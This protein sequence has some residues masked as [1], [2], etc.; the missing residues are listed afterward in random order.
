[1]PRTLRTRAPSGGTRVNSLSR[2]NTRWWIRSAGKRNSTLLISG[3][4]VLLGRTPGGAGQLV[5]VVR[6]G[7]N[8][9]RP[10]PSPE[11]TTTAPESVTA[12]ASGCRTVATSARDSP[13][14]SPRS[15]ARTVLVPVE[16][17]HTRPL[18]GSSATAHGAEGT[19]NIW[20]RRTGEVEYTSSVSPTVSLATTDPLENV[21]SMPAPFPARRSGPACSSSRSMLASTVSGL[22]RAVTDPSRATAIRSIDS[23]PESRFSSAPSASLTTTSPSAVPVRIRPSGVIAAVV[24]GPSPVRSRSGPDGG[25]TTTPSECGT[26]TV[27]S[28]ATDASPAAAGSSTVRSEDHRVPST[29][30]ISRRDGS[31]TWAVTCSPEASSVRTVAGVSTVAPSAGPA[32]CGD[33]A[34]RAWPCS[35]AASWSGW[36]AVWE[37]PLSPN[38]SASSAAGTTERRRARSGTVFLSTDRHCPPRASSAA[39]QVRTTTLC[40]GAATPSGAPDALTRES[41]A[42][43]PDGPRRPGHRRH[44]LDPGHRAVRAPGVDRVPPG[45]VLGAPA[46]LLHVVVRRGRRCLVHRRRPARDGGGRPGV[47]LQG[48]RPHHPRLVP[49]PGG[50]RAS[51]RPGLPARLV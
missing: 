32:A 10:A 21:L 46:D 39:A 27:P 36:S 49:R 7:S 25:T 5:G 18:A 33:S 14:P 22:L 3:Y 12:R 6:S 45:L 37:Q 8:T 19:G 48:H 41:R 17:T 16:V 29:V 1:T 23:R 9:W 35:T 38:T 34:G 20:W 44:V 47:L 11:P 15:Y 42:R 4:T 30:P 40:G 2:P 51:R 26:S 24:T 50:L 28:R 43:E 13:S 31:S